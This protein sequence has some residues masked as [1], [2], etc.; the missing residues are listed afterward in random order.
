M[1]TILEVF[2]EWIPFTADSSHKHLIKV[3]I[4][5]VSDTF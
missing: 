3:R 2:L 1:E 4:K 5:L